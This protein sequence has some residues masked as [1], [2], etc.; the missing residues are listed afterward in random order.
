M[1]KSMIVQRFLHWLD[2]APNSSRADAAAAL[3]RARLYS[4]M[5]V[6]EC[7]AADAALT[8]LLDD[9]SSR[10]RYAMADVLASHALAPRHLIVA[11]A[12]DQSDIAMLVLCRSPLFLDSELE[13]IIASGD[14][15]SLMA[16]ACR[17]PLSNYVADALIRAENYATCLALLQ[18]TQLKLSTDN[19]RSIADK[20]G[21][22]AEI[23]EAL[24]AGN[25]L[26]A[27]IRQALI[28]E[29]SEA[30]ELLVVEKSWL[31]K[32]RAKTIVREARDRSTVHLASNVSADET[33][34]LVE[35]LRKSGQLTA[36]F[37]LRC[38]CGGNIPLFATAIANLSSIPEARIMAVLQQGRTAAFR[39]IY[40]RSGLPK[41]AIP[42]IT[43]AVDI[44]RDEAELNETDDD[45]QVQK[46]VMDRIVQQ[47]VSAVEKPDQGLLALLRRISS[48]V[49]RDA[50]LMRAREL[51][52]AA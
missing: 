20:F 1:G 17:Q 32:S 29:M 12:K 38:V 44:W 41:A 10:V 25:Y 46:L 40:D 14:V 6:Q 28:S 39:A 48:E 7:E 33:P 30:L 9:P 47:Y 26:P 2:T 43:A 21:G 34:Q 15:V 13:E 27:D 49:T 36:A 23:R 45:I 52:S 5:S 35:R 19:L 42:A 24:L 50:A 8:L 51:S 37:L 11:L 18:N 4:D 16:I 31:S 22:H 3:A